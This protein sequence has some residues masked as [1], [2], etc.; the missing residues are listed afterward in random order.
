MHSEI[1]E[2]KE[3]ERIVVRTEFAGSIK[4]LETPPTLRQ[5]VVTGPQ[6]YSVGD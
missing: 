5:R 1:A 6:R 2:L 4:R 3:I